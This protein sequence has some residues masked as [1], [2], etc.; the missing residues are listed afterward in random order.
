MTQH[1]RYWPFL[2]LV[3]LGTS[4]CAPESSVED[5]WI[6]EAELT[7]LL[8][9]G[10]DATAFFRGKVLGY[11]FGDGNYFPPF[12]EPVHATF[13]ANNAA[14]ANDFLRS[15]C[16]SG[17][18]SR[19]YV[20]GQPI[21]CGSLTRLTRGAKIEVRD[22]PWPYAGDF[23]KYAVYGGAW[24]HRGFLS[25]LLPVEG[26]TGGLIDDHA[27]GV[28]PYTTGE[29]INWKMTALLRL[30]QNPALQFTTARKTDGNGGACSGADCRKVMVKPTEGC[31]FNHV[32]G[33]Q[34]ISFSR[35]PG[36]EC[37]DGQCQ[38]PLTCSGP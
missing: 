21:Q 32:Y 30:M 11:L 25:G 33:Y 17:Y 35:V 18:G 8:A 19:T 14:T 10:D 5:T 20:E 16:R 1:T 3:F 28:G 22:F 4:A 23:D 31:L 36:A 7:P 38:E 26:S 29:Q 37:S 24:S 13:K 6:D 2:M 12:P 34:F 27:V 15:A 9:S